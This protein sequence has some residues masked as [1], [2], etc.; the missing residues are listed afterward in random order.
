MK[1]LLFDAVKAFE[2]NIHTQLE[3]VVETDSTLTLEPSTSSEH[4]RI[5][6]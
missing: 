3:T 2:D 1:K 5:L 4:I 6:V